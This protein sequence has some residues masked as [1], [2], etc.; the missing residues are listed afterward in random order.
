MADVETD[1]MADVETDYM[2][3]VAL[4]VPGRMSMACAGGAHSTIQ[5]VFMHCF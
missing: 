5:S 2:A 4:A 1:D 3:D